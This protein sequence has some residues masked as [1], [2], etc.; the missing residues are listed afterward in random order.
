M[1][2]SK[3]IAMGLGAGV[4]LG[5]SGKLLPTPFMFAAL[6]GPA[7]GGG[8]MSGV[9]VTVKDS[10]RRVDIAIDGQ[11]FTSYLW[12]AKQRK[13]VLYPLLAPDG[14]TLTR[15]N[16]PMPGERT[17]HPHH[18]GLWFN[19]SNVNNIDYWNNSDA[20]KPEAR[21]RYGSIDH[22]RIVSAK[23]GATS[24]ELVTESTWYPSSD[25]P[26]VGSNQQ[27]AVLHQTTRYVFSKLMIDGKPA[28]AI[29]MTVTLKAL[30]T[31]VFH[32]DKDG[33]LGLRVAHFLESA[34]AKPETLRD[35][36]GIA[37]PVAGSTAG[38]T[39]V[40]RTSEGKVGDAAWGTRGKW[41]ELSGTTADGK[42]ET[43]A[44]FDHTGNPN[45]P[46]YWHARD[47]GLFAVN[48]LGAH[49][50]DPKGPSLN[51]TLD[52][53][54]SATFHYRVLLISGTVSVDALNHQ[55]DAFD[56]EK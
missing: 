42:A 44:I 28:R 39:G 16:P 14:T 5:C 9:S 3:L 49:G 29:D 54:K 7:G 51:F 33:M 20:I 31:A 10:E 1:S 43:I 55:S 37:T 22:D 17:D 36:N 53:G 4:L 21:A 38:A 6:A 35:A 32:D 18:I 34:T 50:F 56:K 40:Y 48:P 25:V 15:G 26:S 45:Y 11:P 46:T 12:Q 41:C 24:G 23:S 47:Y 2:M 30:Q 52:P 19:Y 13:P 8:A 27:P